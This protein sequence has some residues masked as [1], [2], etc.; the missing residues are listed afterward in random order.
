[1]ADLKEQFISLTLASHCGKLHQ[2][3]KRWNLGLLLCPINT[4]EGLL[5]D[6][7]ILSKSEE[8]E[9]SQLKQ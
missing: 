5:M 8:S 9:A 6:K 4:A 2:K 3:Y 1:M 7:S